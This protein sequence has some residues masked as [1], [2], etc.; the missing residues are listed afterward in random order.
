LRIFTPLA[1]Q[2]LLTV[3]SVDFEKQDYPSD[4]A[5]RKLIA[6]LAADV[7][8]N[9]VPVMLEMGQNRSVSVF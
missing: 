5:T 4:R 2:D 1:I 9:Q 6:I 7:A 8:G 3:L